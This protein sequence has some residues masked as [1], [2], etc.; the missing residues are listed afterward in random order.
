MKAFFESKWFPIIAYLVTMVCWYFQ[1][2][3]PTICFAAASIILI[4]VSGA[5]RINIV[6]LIFAGIISYRT[7]SYEGNFWPFLIAG[8]IVVPLSVYDL[9]R[10][11]ASLK[12]PIFIALAL[13]FLSGLVSLVNVKREYLNYGIAGIF[14]PLIFAYLYLYLWNSKEKE[15]FRRVSE[16]ATWLSVAITLQVV[17]FLL[18]YEGQVLGKRINL[19]WSSTNSLAMMYLLLF[20][21][22]LYLYLD[23]GE[24]YVLPILGL[25][26][27][28]LFLTLSKGAYLAFAILLIPF[29]V[30]VYKDINNKRQFLYGILMF[31]V[32]AILAL[33]VMFAIPSIREGAL[34][35][36]RKMSERGWF[37]D[38]ARIE[39]YR[40]GA[41]VFKRYPLFGSGIYTA[42]P[43]LIEKGYSPE[44]KHYH[45]YVIQC[46]ATVGVFGLLAFGNFILQIFRKAWKHPYNIAVAFAAAAM[47]LHGLVDNTWHNPIIMTVMTVYLAFLVDGKKIDSKQ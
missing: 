29:L 3:L 46:L 31:A 2:Q 34:E 16:S 9:V 47:L 4:I 25:D 11:K 1:I 44:L 27:A 19:G 36:L 14:Q 39:I 30:Y 37:N 21:L 41:E 7:T 24:W 20:P 43:Y 10:R 26:V 42:K 12:D 45:N 28:A 22:T 23:K 38:K 13:C 40:Y 33:G 15:D 35:Y 6:T 8:L 5:K 17:I 18:T 32:F